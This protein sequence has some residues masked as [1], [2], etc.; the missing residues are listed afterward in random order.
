[1]QDLITTAHRIASRL[2][3]AKATL[4]V[5]ESSAGGLISAALLSV[6]G[7]SA[8]FVGGDIVYTR[9]SRTAFGITEADMAGLRSATEPYAALLAETARA[10]LGTVWALAE[11]GA[12]GPSGNRYG[13]PAGH[14]CFAVAGPFELTR[15][16]ETGSADRQANMHAFAAAALALLEDAI[17]S[18]PG[19]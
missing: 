19:A 2:I 15:V 9:Q 7:A 12:T 10:R 5:V 8:Y 13:D 3:A 16:L 14:A 17:G 18:V 1:M 11:T 4:C 6:P